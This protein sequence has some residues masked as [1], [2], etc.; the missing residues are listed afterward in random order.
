[1]FQKLDF[2]IQP[3][4][5][6]GPTLLGPLEKANLDHWTNSKV[7]T[8]DKVQNPVILRAIQHRHNP[9]GFT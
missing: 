1:M 7:W 9:L 8:M 6:G 3:E 5:R 4:V 2:S